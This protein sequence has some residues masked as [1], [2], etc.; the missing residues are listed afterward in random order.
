[1]GFVSIGSCPSAIC[2]EELPVPR[3]NNSATTTRAT[4]TPHVI[5]VYFLYS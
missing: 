1:V 2:L 5:G 4:S 3:L